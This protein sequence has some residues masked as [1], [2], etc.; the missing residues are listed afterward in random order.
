MLL[1]L[2]VTENRFYGAAIGMPAAA[3]AYAAPIPLPMAACPT[4]PCH[5]YPIRT[6]IVALNIA[7]R[8]GRLPLVA[9]F[10]RNNTTQNGALVASDLRL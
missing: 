6:T 3:I 5:Q 7:P 2:P 1:P 8:S 9:G 10:L 4:L